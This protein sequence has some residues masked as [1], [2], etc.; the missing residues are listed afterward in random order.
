V[1]SETSALDVRRVINEL[2]NP[3]ETV[4]MKP[5]RSVIVTVVVGETISTVAVE[6]KVPTLV[7][8]EGLPFASVV[9]IKLVPTLVMGTSVVDVS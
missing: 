1:D 7:M 9:E 3:E 2:I 6:M 4:V 8:V 5:G